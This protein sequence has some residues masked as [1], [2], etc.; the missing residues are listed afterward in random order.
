MCES[1]CQRCRTLTLPLT[2]E[3]RRSYVSF[4]GTDLLRRPWL[5]GQAHPFSIANMPELTMDAQTGQQKLQL[6]LRVKRGITLELARLVER[7]STEHGSCHLLVS[8]EGPY[9]SSP[10]SEEYDSLILVTGG[11]GITH[12][13]SV[14]E[15]ACLR[16]E[17]GETGTTAVKLVWAVR[18]LCE[19]TC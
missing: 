6:V 15:D 5:Y 11:S 16:A 17:K 8:V 4:W 18:H 2:L 7:M 13:A 12:V 3:F 10:R 9:G 14:L 1:P 19:S